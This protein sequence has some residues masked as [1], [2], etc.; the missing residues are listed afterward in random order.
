[1]KRLLSL[2]L[3][4]ILISTSTPTLADSSRVRSLLANRSA[5]LLERLQRWDEMCTRRAERRSERLARR[6]GETEQ[7]LPSSIADQAC[8]NIRKKLAQIPLQKNAEKPVTSN[9]QPVTSNSSQDEP[10]TETPDEDLLP[11]QLFTPT[12]PLPSIE[13]SSK[14]LVLGKKEKTIGS[15]KLNPQ[16]EPVEVREI[17]IT[18]ASAVESLSSI[19]IFDEFGMALGNAAI[20]IAESAARDVFT[21]NLNPDNAYFIDKDDEIVFAFR[22]HLIS[23]DNGGTSGETL[24]ISDVDITTI[25]RWTS[26]TQE[27]TTSGQDFK[28]HRTALTVLKKIESTGSV[29][30]TFSTG[31]DKLIGSFKFSALDVPDP[32]ADPR[33]TSI[34]FAVSAPSKV[35]VA[36]PTLRDPAAGTET[37]CTAAGSEITCSSIPSDVGSIEEPRELFIYSDV[38]LSSD[39]PNPFL[40]LEINRPGG[41]SGG[42]DITWTDG[43]TSFSWVPLTQPVARGTSWE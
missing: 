11:N 26:N 37:S 30:S 15:I 32:D 20:D 34:T 29:Q 41:P 1:M 16:D 4:L 5:R 8:T 36:N 28:A 3:T 13:T 43:V 25:G 17:Q 24:Q 7:I 23:N 39:H 14:F 19:E 21:L 31:I 12:Y 6:E 9:Q 18:L 2:A 42:G 22:P 27:V 10:Q 38:S 40:Q 33:I 35:V